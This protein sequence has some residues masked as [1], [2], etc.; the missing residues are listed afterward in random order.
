MRVQFML[1]KYQTI[2]DAPYQP[3]KDVIEMCDKYHDRLEAIDLR[4]QIRQDQGRPV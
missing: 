3:D 1:A 2:L 4:A